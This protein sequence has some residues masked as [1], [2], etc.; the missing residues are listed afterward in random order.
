MALTVGLNA[1]E[2]TFCASQ[3]KLNRLATY[4]AILD[5]ALMINA[6][7]YNNRELFPTKWTGH[8]DFRH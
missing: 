1:E 4:K 3:M 5:V 8:I 7:V 6:T 2:F